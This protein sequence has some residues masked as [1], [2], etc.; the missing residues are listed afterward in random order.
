[1]TPEHR[2]FNTRYS[3]LWSEGAAARRLSGTAVDTAIA[4][5]L[6]RIVAGMRA[7]LDAAGP[8]EDPPAA[9][10]PTDDVRITWKSLVFNVGGR[11]NPWAGEKWQAMLASADACDRLGQRA[12]GDGYRALAARLRSEGGEAP[13]P[14]SPVIAARTRERD[15]WTGPP[16]PPAHDPVPFIAGE[17]M[18]FAL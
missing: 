14:P 18:G 8:A 13:A 7:E 9:A 5:A 6:D 4:G 1:M 12:I 11:F 10:A 15:V 17:Q 16:Q 3:A 2:A